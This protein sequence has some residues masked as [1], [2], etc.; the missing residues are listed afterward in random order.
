MVERFL[1]SEGYIEAIVANYFG[2][3]K[4]LITVCTYFGLDYGNFYKSCFGLYEA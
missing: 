2:F 3:D 4:K 1:C